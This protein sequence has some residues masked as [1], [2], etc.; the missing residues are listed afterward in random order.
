MVLLLEYVFSVL[1]PPLCI[2]NATVIY[3]FLFPQ[4]VT[5]YLSFLCARLLDLRNET[6]AARVIQGAWRR[7]KLQKDIEL[8]RVRVSFFYHVKLLGTLICLDLSY[9][10]Y[11]CIHS[12]RTWLPLKSKPLCGISSWEEECFDR[13]RQP[14]RSKHSG[15]DTVLEKNWE[16]W[17][18][19]DILL[20]KM[21]LQ[22]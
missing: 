19:R 3:S 12:K 13:I 9:V 1:F 22:L 2:F 10:E 11:V 20:F 6:R 21:Q 5:C 14:S 16:C 4:V 18:K 15:E 7:Y 17:K 8:T